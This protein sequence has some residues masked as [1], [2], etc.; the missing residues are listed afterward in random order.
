MAALPEAVDEFLRCRRIAVAGVSRD[1][2]QPANLIYRKL[3]STGHDVFAVNPRTDRV[4]DAACFP[5][6]AAI[7][8]GVEAVVVA[9][10]PEAALGIVRDCAQLGIPRVWLH[11]SFG[12]GSVSDDCVAE[13]RR[14]GV[15]IIPGGCPM[16]FCPPV[17]LGHRCMR[18]VLGL[19]GKLSR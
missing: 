7:P 13:G 19:T 4:E 16:M 17:D 8:G 1:T 14:L 18:F 12:A 11:R 5:D 3:R 15:S 6:L 9:T 10:P 2:K